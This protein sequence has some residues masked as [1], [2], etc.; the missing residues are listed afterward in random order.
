MSQP[1]WFD[2][3]SSERKIGGYL[4]EQD[5]LFF[6]QVCQLLFDCDPMMIPLVMEPQGYAPEVGSILRVLPQCQSEDDVREVVHNIFVQ[7]FSS[8]FAG[9]PGQY[10]EAASK[11]WALWIAQQSE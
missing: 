4:Q 11:L 5:P 6:E 2:W 8:E 9:C 1:K 7:W 3:A 10:S